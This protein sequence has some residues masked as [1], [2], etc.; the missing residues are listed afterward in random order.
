ME[1]KAETSKAPEQQV[2]A[3]GTTPKEAGLPGIPEPILSQNKFEEGGYSAQYTAPQTFSVREVVNHAK[4]KRKV[5]KKKLYWLGLFRRHRKGCP[6]CGANPI[7][8]YGWC[9]KHLPEW[10]QYND[11]EVMALEAKLQAQNKDR[12]LIR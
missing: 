4:E 10:K 3:P 2:V 11:A 8:E 6:Y 1:F 12:S 7:P 9:Y 5:H